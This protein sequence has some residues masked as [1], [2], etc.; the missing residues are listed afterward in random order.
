[1]ETKCRYSYPHELV[2][3]DIQTNAD[4]SWAEVVEDT[5]KVTCFVQKVTSIAGKPY[6]TILWNR[7]HHFTGSI[8]VDCQLLWG[9]STNLQICYTEKSISQYLSKYISKV[10]LKSMAVQVLLLRRIGSG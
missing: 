10:E 5:P 8:I 7:N 1:M 4:M 9:T 2:D 3:H 6:N